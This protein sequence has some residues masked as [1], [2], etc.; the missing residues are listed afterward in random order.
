MN[1]VIKN[2]NDLNAW[3]EGHKLVL[4]IYKVLSK[5]PREEKYALSDQLKRAAVSVTSCIAEGFSRR[6][7]KDKAQFYRMSQGSLTE[8]QNQIDIAF[9]LGYLEEIGYKEIKSQSVVV[10]K[11]LSG[12]IKATLENR[13]EK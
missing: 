3:K 10:H 9:D 2:Y 13:F 8:T 5:F 1:E 7:A 11:L 12:L 6:T 4:L